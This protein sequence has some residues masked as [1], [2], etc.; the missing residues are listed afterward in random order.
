MEFNG[1]DFKI[2]ID[3]LNNTEN[4]SRSLR[5]W[6]PAHYNT[7][8]QF[9]LDVHD[10]DIIELQLNFK[11]MDF[12]NSSGISMLCTFILEIKKLNKM[13]VKII[14][15]KNILWQTKSFQNLKLLWDRL[16]LEFV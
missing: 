9:L 13:P 6:T 11:N 7:I 1:Q 4:L 16:E 14:G 12:L 10:L 3:N 2:N 5:L 8:K 15:N